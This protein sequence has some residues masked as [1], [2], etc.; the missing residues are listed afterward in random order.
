MLLAMYDADGA[1]PEEDQWVEIERLLS[2]S[3]EVVEEIGEPFLEEEPDVKK[4]KW[5][6]AAEK[7]EQTAAEDL[8]KEQQALTAKLKKTAELLSGI[9]TMEKVSGQ[10][11]KR[12]AR[13]ENRQFTVSLFGVFS[14]GKSSFANA[15]MGEKLL[16]VS[17]NPTTAA[18][19]R[20]LPA[21]RGH[22]S[23]TGVVTFKSEEQ[24]LADIN[25]A[26][27]KFG[28]EAKTLDEGYQY[29][30]KLHKNKE[31]N[32]VLKTHLSFLNAF[33][34]GYPSFADKL[35]K[36]LTVN[37]DKF[38]RFVAEEDKSCF[39]EGIDFYTDSPVTN[40]GITFVDT[41][42]ADSINARHTDVAF[43]YIKNADA[44]IFVTYYN[45]A[46]SKADREFLI[47]LGR[48]KDQFALD[49]MFFIVNAVDLAP[50]EE[51]L[52][53]VL[54]YVEGELLK[55]GIR[56]VKLYP[57][58]SL[59]ALKEKLTGEKLGSGFPDFEHD[60]YRFIT[61]DLRK[62]ALNTAEQ[63]WKQAQERL[64]LLVETA[65]TDL[66]EREAKL[67]TLTAEEEKIKHILDDQASV[68]MKEQLKQEAKEL[69]YYI[70]QRH[71][72]RFGD[73]FRETFNPAT[74]K[75]SGQEAKRGLEAA[76]K[77]LLT[78]VGFDLAQELRATSLRLENY[79]NK[80][81]REQYETVAGQL[82][83]INR[84]LAFSLFE[85]KKIETPRFENEIRH[86]PAGRFAKTLGLFKNP[87]LFFEG[88]G[89]KQMEEKLF[90]DL[91]SYVDAYLQDGET[92]LIEKYTGFIDHCFDDIIARFSEESAE[93]YNGWR[94]I[95]DEKMDI[96]RLK[97]ILKELEQMTGRKNTR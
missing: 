55:F 69:V 65:E 14:A 20:I 59:N 33:H 51:D 76:L 46:F 77:E 12:A 40:K 11:K 1:T 43:E 22:P 70:K 32:Q 88:N 38:Q 79:A 75:G 26:L 52:E 71:Q 96:D 45:H 89:K 97:N 34:K 36:K 39:V 23:G 50:S 66:A 37:K 67:Q 15:L 56:N 24:M 35:G 92:R 17:P 57:V 42:G 18:I 63:E 84:N 8:G 30:E 2:G 62:L 74:I 7:K 25:E 21:G 61:H 86:I 91:S 72:Y 48:V 83:N 95:L 68:M 28:Y 4:E 64:A 82:K 31:E 10:L 54:A 53:E 41:P 3:D 94:S 85:E 5:K 80:K 81:L 9:P 93:Q 27:E 78:A 58:S 29:V 60:F 16:P 47:Q 13:L 49:K 44:I 73:F 19:N 87:K 6:R 90:E